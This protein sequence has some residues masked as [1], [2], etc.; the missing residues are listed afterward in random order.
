MPSPR[1]L[2]GTAVLAALAVASAQDPARGEELRGLETILDEI[3][4]LEAGSDPK[5]NASASRL[6]DFIYGTPLSFAA[7]D[8][9][10]ELQKD[11]VL[12]A[13]RHAA[14][15]ATGDGPVDLAA[16]DRAAME[17]LGVRRLENGAVEVTLGDL[18]RVTLD[19]LDLRH[20]ASVAFALRA[21]L[22]VE[23]ENLLAAQPPLPP[24]A[25]EAVERLAE[26][27]NLHTLAA[28]HLADLAARAAN[29]AALTA[30]GVRAAWRRVGSPLEPVTGAG[31]AAGAPGIVEARRAPGARFPV[32]GRIVEQK[33]ASYE[34]YNAVSLRLFWQN[35]R[36]YIARHPWPDADEELGRL[37]SAFARAVTMFVTDVAERAAG[38]SRAAGEPLIRAAAVETVQHEPAPF[39][40]NHY[41]DVVFFPR[42]GPAE[43]VT[44]ESYDMDAFRDSGLHWKYLGRAFEAGDL[45]VALEPDPFAAELLAEAAAQYGVLVFRVAGTLAREAAA[46]AMT[47]EHIIAAQRPAQGPAAAD[48]ARPEPA[49]PSTAPAS[50][51]AQN[52]KAHG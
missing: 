9:K 17:L 51:P 27:V 22:A 39:H 19:P 40:V 3:G 4:A 1:A 38:L 2:L 48:P 37:Q 41:E 29:E 49:P 26:L 14:A 23:Q 6:E 31:A 10:V 43:R 5:C 34:A 44:I 45:A 46:P 16:M 11:L 28:L 7:R 32:L 25:P 50:A 33:L 13:W 47:A 20:Y 30:A 15:Q 52:G 8:A 21:V 36:S 35:L 18:A 42:L 12:R 24:L